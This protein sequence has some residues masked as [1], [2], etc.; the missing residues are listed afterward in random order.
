[1]APELDQLRAMT[2]VVADTGDLGAVAR[3]KH[4]SLPRPPTGSQSRLESRLLP[5]YVSNT[6][7][8]DARCFWTTIPHANRVHVQREFQISSPASDL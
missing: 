1:L 7:G 6:D 2:T 3:L 5:S 8:T 4:A